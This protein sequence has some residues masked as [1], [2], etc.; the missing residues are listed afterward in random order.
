MKTV[1]DAILAYPGVDD[2]EGFLSVVLTDRG[3]DGAAIYTADAS[4]AARL[5]VA[6]VYAMIGGLPDFT[7]YKL[8]VSYP[9]QWYLSKARELYRDNGEGEKATRLGGAFV[10]RGKAPQTW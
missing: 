3:L 1:K 2:G 9:R 4:R 5:A 7:E 6:D 10:P 8:T